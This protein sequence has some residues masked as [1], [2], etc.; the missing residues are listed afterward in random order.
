MSLIPFG[1]PWIRH[2]PSSGLALFTKSLH[3]ST[4]MVLSPSSFVLAIEKSLDPSLPSNSKTLKQP[5]PALKHASSPKDIRF[6]AHLDYENTFAPVAKATS[7]RL[8]L[9]LAAG[10]RHLV[11][12]FDVET[13]FLKSVIDR[14]IYIEQPDQGFEHPDF[15]AK[16]T[17]SKS[18]KDSTALNRLAA[19]TPMI[20]RTR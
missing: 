18:T 2:T 7:V 15:L 12:L 17:S 20:R 5:L 16:T 11:N 1:K 6:V 14:E 4:T 8:V 10:R 13:A 19:S 9:A 3:Q